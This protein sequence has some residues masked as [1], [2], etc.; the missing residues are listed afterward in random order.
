MPFS[1]TS[2]YGSTIPVR[3]YKRKRFYAKKSSAMRVARR[4]MYQR[5]TGRA[6]RSQI[7]SLSRQVALNTSAIQEARE[8]GQ[9]YKILSGN[10]STP[11]QVFLLSDPENW[12]RC[13]QDASDI[14]E[15]SKFFL[16][17]MNIDL[18]ISPTTENDPIDMTCYFFQARP[19]VATKVMRETNNMTSLG[20]NDYITNT[21]LAMMNPG[22]YKVLKAIRLTTQATNSGQVQRDSAMHREYIK[23][24]PGS[25]LQN[26]AGNWTDITKDDYPEA[27]RIFFICFNNNSTVDTLFPR[28]KM[29]VVYNGYT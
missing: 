10:V 11:F 4:A 1:R 25:V 26:A 22:R 6:Q 17:T 13:F 19:E 24:K 18:K 9:Y 23:F 15:A 12:T 2:T 29:T 3:N 21:G 28:V 8:W 27:E 7:V 16:T 5:P 20:V 14:R